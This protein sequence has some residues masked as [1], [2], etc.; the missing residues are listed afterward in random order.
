MRCSILKRARLALQSPAGNIARHTESSSASVIEQF[1]HGLLHQSA[2]AFEPACL[3]R[4]PA[5]PKFLK[6][7]FSCDLVHHSELDDVQRVIKRAGDHPQLRSRLF[8]ERPET[9]IKTRKS[10]A[11]G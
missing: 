10:F 1:K 4:A 7:R 3:V 11:H 8:I 2:S 9:G 5:I 6:C